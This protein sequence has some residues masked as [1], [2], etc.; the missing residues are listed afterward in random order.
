MRKRYVRNEKHNFAYLTSLWKKLT[1]WL[2]TNIINFA[3][4]LRDFAGLNLKSATSDKN[5]SAELKIPYV[6][7]E[8]HKSNRELRK[9]LLS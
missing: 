8:N 7:C 9:L 3:G 6:T 4:F 5:T 1:T 2:Q